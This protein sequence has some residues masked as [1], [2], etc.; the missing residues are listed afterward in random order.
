MSYVYEPD[1]EKRRAA[2]HALQRKKDP[3]IPAEPYQ[4]P[5]CMDLAE[6]AKHLE[7]AASILLLMTE[8]KNDFAENGEGW[9]YEG[10]ADSAARHLEAA[11]AA[12]RL[13]GIRNA[14]SSPP[15]NIIGSLSVAIANAREELLRIE[16]CSEVRYTRE[17]GNEP[18]DDFW[19]RRFARVHTRYGNDLVNLFRTIRGA[20]ELGTVPQLPIAPITGHRESTLDKLRRIKGGKWPASNQTAPMDTPTPAAPADAMAELVKALC[21]KKSRK[22][23]SAIMHL[24][25]DPD[26]SDRAIANAQGVS[27]STVAKYRK[28]LD[29][30][31]DRRTVEREQTDPWAV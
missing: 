7:L 4:H 11:G 14:L 16:D 21:L 23:Q 13:P 28:A 6:L 31:N 2:R 1:R 19:Q 27:P 22:I 30:F 8:H 25:R 18:N 29:K 10:A 3:S 24:A 15:F 12:I 17:G 20:A 5:A 9:L 26:V